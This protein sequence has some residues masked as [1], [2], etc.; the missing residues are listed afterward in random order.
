MAVRKYYV[1]SIINEVR[2]KSSKRRTNF[3][4][5]VITCDV[6]STSAAFFTIFLISYFTAI[7]INV[8]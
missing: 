2:L 8:Y 6:L 1:T 3:V 4:S 5:M 7:P